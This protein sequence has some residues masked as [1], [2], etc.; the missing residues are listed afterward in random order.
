MKN[1]TGRVAVFFLAGGLSGM[2]MLAS[3]LACS[4]TEAKGTTGKEATTASGAESSA[5]FERAAAETVALMKRVEDAAKAAGLPPELGTSLIASARADG[6]RLEAELS[7]PGDP[8]LTLL[9]DKTHP[10]SADYEP[11]DLVPLTG[12]SYTTSRSGFRLRAEAAA[13]LETM[14]KAA[15]AEGVG[16]LVSSTYRSYNYQKTVYERIVTELGQEAADRESARPGHSQHQLGLA[17]DFGS[18]DDSFAATTASRWLAA[19][20]ARFGWSLSYAYGM[21]TITGYRWESWHYR[22]VG[23]PAATMIETRFGGVQQYGFAFLR[24]WRAGIR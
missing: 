24:E 12:P 13:A 10:L 1:L 20:A 14:A 22:Y 11:A 3:L 15:N 23:I 19:N 9:V 17:V 6:T 5:A 16:L 8:Y 7:L 18:I 21:E 2:L 4:Q